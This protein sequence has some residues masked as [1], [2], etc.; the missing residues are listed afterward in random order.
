MR[1]KNVDTTQLEAEFKVLVDSVGEEIEAKLKQ[2]KKLVKEA[3][4]LSQEH[5][6]PFYSP[7]SI[8]GECYVPNTF[9]QRFG[10]LK[11]EDV[12]DLTSVP[13]EEL[14]SVYVDGWNHSQVC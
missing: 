1:R 13:E 10:A 4:K 11:P 14:K 3:A 12:A 9:R 7:V 2:A 5:G 6:V 8:L